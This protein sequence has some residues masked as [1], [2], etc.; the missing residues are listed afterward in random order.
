MPLIRY[1]RFKPN[2]YLT[3]PRRFSLL[4]ENNFSPPP[5]GLSNL[6][7]RVPIPSGSR[8][9]SRSHGIIMSIRFVAASWRYPRVT[10]V[11]SPP[12]P[13]SVSESIRIRVS[14]SQS[15]PSDYCNLCVQT[16]RP[17]PDIAAIVI[18]QGRHSHPQITTGPLPFK[19]T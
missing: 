10:H 9:R 2:T 8:S 7:S 14:L 3:C 12:A 19:H 1:A 11:R 18:T 15:L 4:D 13:I 5:L 17:Q 16:Q 6:C